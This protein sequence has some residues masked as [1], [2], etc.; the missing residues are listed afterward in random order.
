MHRF[1]QQDSYP[2]FIS[3]YD[4]GDGGSCRV[5][6]HADTRLGQG[7]IYAQSSPY[8]TW[9]L[10][11]ADPND[12]DRLQLAQVTEIRFEFDLRYSL[13]AFSGSNMLFIDS[14]G[15]TGEL[16][17]AAC[18]EEDANKCADVRCGSHGRCSGDT[19][20]CVCDEGWSGDHCHTVCAID[21]G[22]HGKCTGPQ[23]QCECELGWY[24]TQCE[25]FDV[26]DT[27]SC[28][29]HGRCMV[30][31]PV[32]TA[33]GMNA[34]TIAAQI[35]ELRDRLELLISTGEYSKIAGVSTQIA[36]LQAQQEEAEE[37]E[38]AAARRLEQL[39]GQLAA[40]QE[41][42]DY[43]TVARV[44]HE[45]EAE[46]SGTPSPPTVA[47]ASCVC[48]SGWSG[49]SCDITVP[50]SSFGQVGSTVGLVSANSRA[51]VDDLPFVN[52]LDSKT[53]LGMVMC[54]VAVAAAA[55]IKRHVMAPT[56]EA[57]LAVPLASAV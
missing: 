12:L 29:S 31:Q 34:T 2:A 3:E 35:E 36:S 51:V 24:G 40:A 56:A 22:D 19:G 49:D 26:C 45:L 47:Q 7:Q 21:C 9:Q 11:L 55:T 14:P 39:Q 10:S 37:V 50:F 32:K 20:Q 28:G 18:R 15:C 42:G 30:D 16:G 44:A 38:A 46:T 8:G 54:L 53:V 1:T 25:S 52:K 17:P 4:G 48:D 57:E 13:G 5:L 43:V 33:V 41:A 23:G 27:V 6:S